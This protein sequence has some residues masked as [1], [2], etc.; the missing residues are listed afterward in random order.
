MVRPQQNLFLL[1]YEEQSYN[2]CL[3]NCQNG[4]LLRLIGT[5][6]AGDKVALPQL[7]FSCTFQFHLPYILLITLQCVTFVSEL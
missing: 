6:S 2:N 7:F 1:L 4:V 5:L 3:K